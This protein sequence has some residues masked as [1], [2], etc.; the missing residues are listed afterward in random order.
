[1]CALS[2]IAEGGCLGV[3]KDGEAILLHRPRGEE[4][5]AFQGLC[6]HL[7]A[8]LAK[9]AIGEGLVVCPFHHA[10]F[11]LATGARRHGPGLG[12]LTRYRVAVEKGDVLVG[13]AVAEPA[14][15]VDA[16]DPH[17][18]VV[19]AGAA[20]LA[21]V[22]GLRGL[23]HRG[24][25]TLIDREGDPLYERTVLSK[26][27][28]ATGGDRASI[29]RI[30]RETLEAMGVATRFAT[31]V[32][33]I[34]RAGRAVV[35]EGGERV[36]YDRCFLAPGAGPKMLDLPGHD[37]EGVAVLRSVEDAEAIAAK[38]ARPGPVVVIGGGFIGMETASA[39][40]EAGR[41]VVLV[42]PESLP[43]EKPLGRDIAGLVT[44]RLKGAGVRLM[45]E[46]KPGA[47]EGEDGRLARVRLASGATVDTALALVAVGEARRGDLAGGAED[48]GAVAVSADLEADDALWVGGDA[49]AREGA[50]TRHWRAAEEEGRV[51]ASAMLGRSRPAE[52]IPF[53][54]SK[55]G[56]PLHMAGD[57]SP[58]LEF[59]D[60][61][62][63]GSG[64]FTRWHLADGV[65]VGA[66]GGGSQDRTAAYH[67]ARLTKGEVRRDALEAAGWDPMRLVA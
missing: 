32:E 11:E 53:F 51:A 5:V 13:D 28:A 44:E 7:G 25:I 55:I 35:L 37:L 41:E 57:T 21:C 33:R 48:D 42:A 59:V 15:E 52:A 36:P 9:G 61:G 39:L 24:R 66:T 3:D 49:A 56:G 4:V 27:V 45:T 19:G 58:D 12:P 10:V 38:A 31:P 46:E 18:V 2:D 8:P 23:G 29:R 34:D 30:G 16:E 62:S 50:R 54:W 43:G 1:M 67:L 65:V 63:V 60:T 20:G 26:S 6:P 17:V 40:G 64:D 14:F 22:D 47:F